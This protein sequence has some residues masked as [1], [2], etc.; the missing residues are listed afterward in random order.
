MSDQAFQKQVLEQFVQ[1]TVF[2]QQ[3]LERFSKLDADVSE[4]KT[5]VSVLKSDGKNLYRLVEGLYGHMED[6]IHQHSVR[7]S[8]YLHLRG[9]VST[10]D[11][12]IALL[13]RRAA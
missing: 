4:L 2:Q 6:V 13:K 7:R 1:L 10:H 9:W 11:E 3:V 8:E 5:D 12:D